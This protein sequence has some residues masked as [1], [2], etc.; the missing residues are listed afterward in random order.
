[1]LRKCR[2]NEVPIGAIELATQDKE[3]KQYN[4]CLY[5]L[6]QFMEDCTVAQEHNQSFHYNWLLV[7]M[8]FITWKEAKYT[9]FLSVRGECRGVLYA[10]LWAN[11]DPERQCINN[12]VFYTY[13]QQLCT[14]I[15]S[16]PIITKEVTNM[17]KNGIRF[18]EDMHRI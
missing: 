11:V 15:A 17:Y 18:M 1:M 14:L 10:N 2:P 13:Y 9:Q 4:W 6:N 16:R 12:Q 7:L 3:G 5:L 8:V